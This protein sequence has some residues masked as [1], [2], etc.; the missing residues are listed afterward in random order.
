MFKISDISEKYEMGIMRTLLSED[1]HKKMEKI[2]NDYKDKFKKYFILVHSD[3]DATKGLIRTKFLVMR[4][5]PPKMLG[6][7]V[8]LVDNQKGQLRKLWALPRDIPRIE[9]F[10][11]ESTAMSPEDHDKKLDARDMP[12]VY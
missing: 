3:M 6:T 4:E 8:Y 12:I 7:I 5:M 11:D 1:Y 2:L 10:V 9:G